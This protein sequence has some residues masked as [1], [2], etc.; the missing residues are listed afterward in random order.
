[1]SNSEVVLPLTY[2]ELRELL[3]IFAAEEDKTFFDCL[4]GAFYT[5]VRVLGDYAA[6]ASFE[7]IFRRSGALD[8]RI[9]P[10]L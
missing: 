7:I 3:P 5:A 8:W 6:Q 9:I 2:C 1:M 4:A 10:S